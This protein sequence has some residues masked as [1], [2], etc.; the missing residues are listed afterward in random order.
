MDS[1]ETPDLVADALA[2]ELETLSREC[3]LDAARLDSFLSEDFH[4]FGASGVEVVKAGTAE[5]V[6]AYT[7]QSD[8]VLEPSELRGVLIAADV[9]MVKY[10]LQAGEVRS[11]RTSLWRRTPDGR[12]QMFHHQGTLAAAQR[13]D[14]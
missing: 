11:N 4:E 2:A 7:A 6:A 3:R 13:A 9:V 5:R 8:Q 14:G 12:W 1:R 10:V